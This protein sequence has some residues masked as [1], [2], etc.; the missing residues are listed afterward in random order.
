MLQDCELRSLD[1]CGCKDNYAQHAYRTGSQKRASQLL[2]TS[3]ERLCDG[4]VME[5]NQLVGATVREL[6]P[7]HKLQLL[8]SLNVR[9]GMVLT[10]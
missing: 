8:A 7:L 4:D 3:H 2:L 10:N 1:W 9:F 6:V 5:L